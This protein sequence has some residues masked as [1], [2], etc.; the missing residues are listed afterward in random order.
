MRRVEVERIVV[1]EFTTDA[2]EEAALR[3]GLVFPRVVLSQVVAALDAGKHIMLTGPPGTGKTSLAYL[4]ADVARTAVLNTGFLA[5]TASSD[6]DVSDTVGRYTA[7]P[8]GAAF[9]PGVFL[10]AIQTGRWLVVDELNRA[11][12]DKAFGPLFTVLAGQ[13][14]TLPFKQKG[15]TKPLSIVPAGAPTPD[16]TDPVRVPGPWRVI[17]TMNEF[18]K[19]TLYRLSYALMRRFAFIEVEAPPDD[20][21]CELVGGP[22]SIIADLMPVRRFVDLGPA[23]FMDAARYAA[24][25][26]ADPEVSRSRVLFECFYSYLLPQLDRIGERGARDLFEALA[27]RLDGP[28]LHS[29]RR[30]VRKVLGAGP[31]RRRAPIR[32]DELPAA[33]VWDDEPEPFLLRGVS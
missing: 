6:W 10:Q 20:V 18:D 11:D 7:T 9:Q 8:E 30:A 27:P 17:A 15:H 23:V 4:V 24:R 14:V 16:D 21:L 26:S 12:F 32:E 28:E 3:D 22:G 13:S 33:P 25:R 19:D 1:I 5:V 31:E 2:L 29:L